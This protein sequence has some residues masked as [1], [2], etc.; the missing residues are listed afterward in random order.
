MRDNKA[1]RTIS[2]IALVLGIIGV[3]LG[4]AAF[5]VSL[6]ISSSAAVRPDGSNFDVDFSSSESSVQTNAIVPTLNKTVEN[7]TATNGTID[8]TNDPLVSNLKATFTEPGQSATYTFYAYNAGQYLAYLNSIVFSGNKTCTAKSGTTQSL[9]DTACNGISL[10]VKVG[11]ENAT[12]TSIASISE[13]SLA[14][15]AAEEVVV[16][17]EY[18]EN[19][20]RA[21]GDFDVTF[22]DVVLTYESAD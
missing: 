8:N 22:P 18:A 6:K 11:N 9:V 14:A 19:S 20:G 10:S 21:D 4:Y 15:E 16:T 2:I 5:S 1:Y 12:K 3:T 7:F 17:I 13:H